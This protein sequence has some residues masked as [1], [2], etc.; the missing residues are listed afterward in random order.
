MQE[1]RTGVFNIMTGYNKDHRLFTDGR[2]VWAE[3]PYV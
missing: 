3:I 2:K 1:F